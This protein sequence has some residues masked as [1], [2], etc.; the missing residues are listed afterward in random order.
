MYKFATIV[1]ALLALSAA[2]LA[3]KGVDAQTKTIKEEGNKVTTRGNDVTRSFDWGKGKTKIREQLPNPYK[4]TSRRDVLI[5]MVLDALREKK[6]VVDEASSRPKDGIIITQPFVFA[7][8]AVITQNE[9]NRYGI[10]EASYSSW[11]RAQYT[12]TIE[13]QAI[14]GLQN[15]VSVNAKVE[16]RAGNG[17]TSE[18]VTVRSSGIAE[19]EYLAKLVELVTGV[20]PDPVPDKP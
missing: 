4:F 20:S 9:L 7:K 2:A 14:D 15:N 11:T 1:F 3:Q 17:L 5:G 19:D 13:V 12:L 16:G 10:L 6:L 8:G 18:W